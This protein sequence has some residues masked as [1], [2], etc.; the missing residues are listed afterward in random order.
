MSEG[1]IDHDHVMQTSARVAEIFTE[2]LK[3]IVA[4]LSQ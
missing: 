1:E 2:L 4:G 3:R